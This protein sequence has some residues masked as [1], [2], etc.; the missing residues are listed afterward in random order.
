MN[1]E[2]NLAKSIAGRNLQ[3]GKV[4][5]LRFPSLPAPLPALYGVKETT[6]IMEIRLPDNYCRSRKFPLFIFLCGGRGGGGLSIAMKIMGP[7]DWILGGLPL[8]KKQVDKKESY[9]GLLV[10]FEDFPVI[11]RS[12]G[13]MLNRLFRT[14]PNIDSK[15]S[16]IGGGSNGAHTLAV[17]ISGQDGTILSSFRDYF[18][19]EGGML[20]LAD[21]HKRSLRGHRFLMLAGAK[22]RRAARPRKF[23][24]F[25]LIQSRTV[26]SLAKLNGLD[27]TLIVRSDMGHAFDSRC[28]TAV[29]H[30]VCRRKSCA[31]VHN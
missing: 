7:R 2:R 13:T 10:C 3:P 12:Y 9:D 31:I 6:P 1:H 8:F 21:L 19:G 20:Q 30:W 11:S 23:E 24:D 16:V 22:G 26:R 17:L 15:R 4:L 29:R 14:V 5:M 28:M 27:F 18:F 25:Y